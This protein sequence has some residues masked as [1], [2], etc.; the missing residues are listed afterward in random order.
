VLSGFFGGFFPCFAGRGGLIEGVIFF[1]SALIVIAGLKRG[2]AYHKKSVVGLG[3]D[4]QRLVFTACLLAG[5][6]WLSGG[7]FSALV[8]HQQTFNGRAQLPG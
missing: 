1:R 4:N 8:C 7:C 6:G 3:K 2:V 5:T